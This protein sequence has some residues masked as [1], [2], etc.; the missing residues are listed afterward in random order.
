[1]DDGYKEVRFDLYCSSCEHKDKSEKDDPC[2]DC[3]S[4]P[5]N[6]QSVRPVKY[7]EKG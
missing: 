1:M 3:L 7:K 2:D 4:E 6:L 5:V